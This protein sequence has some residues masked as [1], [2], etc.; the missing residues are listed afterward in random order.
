MSRRDRPKF[1]WEEDPWE[2]MN[3]MMKDFSKGFS[4]MG[5]R[6]PVDISETEDKIIVRADLP[7]IPKENVSARF[8]DNKLVI[9]AEQEE[10]KQ[11]QEENYFRHERSFGKLH[12]EIPLPVEVKEDE[13]EAQMEDGVLEIEIP[14]KEKKKEKGK[15]ID[16]R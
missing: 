7:G 4:S 14:K 2:K 5:S 12:R 13:T 3:E 1:F 9:D 10:E 16:I 6:F 15:G 11:E 8:L